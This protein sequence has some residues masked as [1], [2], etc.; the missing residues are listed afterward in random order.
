MAIDAAGSR[1]I[2]ATHHQPTDTSAA[3]KAAGVSVPRGAGS[4]DTPAQVRDSV[5]TLSASSRPSLPAVREDLLEGLTPQEAYAAL[6]AKFQD[7]RVKSAESRLET[8]SQLRSAN[9]PARAE[10]VQKASGNFLS[11]VWN[12]LIKTVTNNPSAALGLVVTTVTSI[13]GVVA[14]GGV[15][16]PAAI[17]AIAAAAMPFVNAVAANAG[18]NL[19][20]MLSKG[21]EE[22]LVFTGVDAK[23]AWKASQVVGSVINL[24]AS[25]GAAVVSG[26]PAV[27]DVN[28]V[29]QFAASIAD[30][31]EMKGSAVR[32]ISET[33][34]GFAS[35]GMLIG[36]S[37]ASGT[38]VLSYGGLDKIFASGENVFK[39]IMQ[40][41]SQGFDLTK[42]GQAGTE[43]ASLVPLFQKLFEQAYTDL[44]SH[45]GLITGLENS[46]RAIVDHVEQS[47]AL[48]QDAL[49]LR[50]SMR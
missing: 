49:A 27:F 31:F 36:G 42:L 47:S 41:F 43:L 26:N 40:S 8:A 18:F 17:G 7:N 10:V 32:T 11:N 9:A 30:A 22:L 6:S 46:Y 23:S 20:Q 2:P 25:I 39:T 1:P 14:S 5:P 50:A 34:R 38:N 45:G 12:A 28:R 3:G 13:A 19:D 35:L 44:Q 24:G 48:A 29:S 21:I 16:I 4:I 15:G 37:I 33:V